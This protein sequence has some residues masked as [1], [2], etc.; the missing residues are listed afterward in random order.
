MTRG[1]I[2]KK[3]QW[4]IHADPWS[5]VNSWREGSY[6]ALYKVLMNINEVAVGLTDG[7]GLDGDRCIRVIPRHPPFSVK[8]EALPA[9]KETIVRNIQWSLRD[10]VMQQI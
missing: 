10:R 1:F 7:L 4:H 6:E 5:L 9:C 2:L 8:E 3:I